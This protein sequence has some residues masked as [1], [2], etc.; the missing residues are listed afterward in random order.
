V[1]ETIHPASY[2]PYIIINTTKRCNLRCRMCFWGKPEVARNLRQDDQTMPMEL[3]RRALEESVPYGRALCLAG[4]GEFLTDPLHEERLQVLGETLRQHPE[5]M[6]YQTTN[7]TLLTADNLR[8]LQG[9]KKVGLTISIDSVDALTYASIRRPGGLS[10]VQATIRSLR[11][12]LHELGLEEI[13]IRLNMVLMKRNI[14]SLPDVLRFAA[15]VQAVVFV[16]HPQGFGPA[17]LH[18]ESLFRFPVFANAFLRK[19]QALAERLNVEFQRPPAFAIR[20]EEIGAY[21]ESLKDRKLSC[22]QLDKEGPVQVSAN[23]DVSVCCQN[24]V[25]GNLN[26]QSFKEIFFSPRYAEYRQAIAEGN[27]LPP[28]DR[29]RHLYRSAPYLYE[30][31]VYG[32]NIPPES[33]NLDPEPDFEKEGFFDWLDELSE[34]QLRHHLR[35]D[36]ASQAKRL[37]GS[38]IEEELAT[39]ARLEKMNGEFLSWIRQGTKVVVCPAGKQSAWL[40]KHTLLPQVDILG[41]ADR[42]PEL[43]GKSF[44]GRQVI[45]PQDIATLKPDIVLISSDIHKVRIQ[46]ELEYLHNAGI[47]VLEL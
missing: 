14:F 25:F 40:L 13:H 3:Y 8:F 30:S 42:N 39:G 38:G 33:R 41:F 35:R 17:D 10:G 22:Y 12:Q 20:P 32:M 36:Y 47:R 29:C 11:S 15:E 45:A 5:I 4:S 43:Q 23:G 9:V 6:L 19:C 34:K 26:R 16:D 31:S 1:T 7:G 28:C 2:R 27:P 24:L 46:S 21:H 44:H 18:L 37:A